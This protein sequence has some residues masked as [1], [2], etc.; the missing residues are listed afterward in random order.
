MALEQWQPGA[1]HNL[2]EGQALFDTTV[3][4]RPLQTYHA[5]LVS[6]QRGEA[7]T[8]AEGPCVRVTH[9]M[10]PLVFGERPEA[11]WPVSTKTYQ[12]YLPEFEEENYRRVS[13][14]MRDVE[15]R[16]ATAE[17]NDNHYS[18][19]SFGVD[20]PDPNNPGQF[21]D[22]PHCSCASLVQSCYQKAGVT[23]VRRESLPNYTA[24]E[25]LEQ[26]CRR[27][28]TGQPELSEKIVRRQ[29]GKWGLPKDEESWPLL[30]PAQ[31]MRA[32]QK[33]THELPHQANKGDH[34]FVADEE[35]R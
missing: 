28:P 20:V 30:L 8:A 3:E 26:F 32:F 15:G 25:I 19:A 18:L 27:D 11:T 33:Q 21:L 22:A 24:A 14:A 35:T 5:M 16:A 10:P 12:G 1:W 2:Q 13:D 31:Q 29:L 4:G 7:L 9:M 6:A 34:P 17:G 23:L